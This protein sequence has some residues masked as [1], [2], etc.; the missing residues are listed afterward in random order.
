MPPR[1]QSSY[2]YTPKKGLI[3]AEFCK[4][5]KLLVYNFPLL[6]QTG[7]ASRRRFLRYGSVPETVG[8]IHSD[9][10]LIQIDLRPP[11]RS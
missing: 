4:I 6:R 7:G 9:A 8:A 3:P 1:N 11:F 5:H 2:H 10:V